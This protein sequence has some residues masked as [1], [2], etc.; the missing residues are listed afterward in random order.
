MSA[1]VLAIVINYCS[2]AITYVPCRW[3]AKKG[4]HVR[5]GILVMNSQ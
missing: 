5:V 4:G 3:G 2:A 1:V